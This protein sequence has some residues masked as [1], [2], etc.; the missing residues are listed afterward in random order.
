MI[1]LTSFLSNTSRMTSK[2]DAIGTKVV[3]ITQRAPEHGRSREQLDR[4]T[5]SGKPQKHL[6]GADVAPFNTAF[7][8]SSTRDTCAGSRD[9]QSI[10]MV[11]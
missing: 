7:H 10:A 8:S 6:P 2:R 4:F 9:T 1:I 3:G 11:A 5:F